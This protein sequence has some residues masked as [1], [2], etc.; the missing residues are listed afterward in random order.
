MRHLAPYLLLLGTAQDGG[1]PQIA[2]DEPP[3]RAARANPALARRVVSALLVDPASGRRWLIDATPD[4]ALQ[5]EAARREAPPPA[6]PGRPPLFEGI[7]LTH[8]HMGHYTGLAQLGREAY[9]CAPTPLYASARM[10]AFLRGNGPWSLLFEAGHLVAER[11]DPL[12]PVELAP[13]LRITPISVEHRAEFSD[14]LAFLIEG[15]RAKILYLPD[16]DRWEGIRPSI[17]EWLSRVDV[18]LIDGTF[19]DGAEL[20]GR[21]LSAIP[22]PFIATSLARFAAEGPAHRPR[23]LF[24]HLNHSNPA[25][26]PHSSARR[27]IEEAGMG[28]A[29]DGQRFAL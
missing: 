10:L 19:Y 14:T 28:V 9:A 3:C 23:I 15:P 8:A 20:P 24:L 17:E 27:T 7:F 5:V 6:G 1:Y 26:D 2:C 29:R 13:G 22:H 16:I 11:L 25:L 21:D 12:S 18:A 4:L